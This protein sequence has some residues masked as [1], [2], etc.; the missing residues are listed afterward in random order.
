MRRV[1]YA[2]E[3]MK[4]GQILGR[5]DVSGQASYSF[6]RSPGCDF[7]LEHPSISRLHAVLQFRAGDAAAFVFD[8]GSAHGTFLNKRRIKPRVHA[9]LRCARPRSQFKRT[10][11]FG[12]LPPH[13]RSS[14]LKWAT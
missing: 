8:A 14:L 4:G 12:L 13:V 7:P 9:P 3:I 1:D 6:G 5:R 2:L 11:T 10:A